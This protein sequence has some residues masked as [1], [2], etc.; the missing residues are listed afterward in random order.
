MAALLP[1]SIQIALSR[2]RTDSGQA[3]CRKGWA[4]IRGVAG[5][6]SSWAIPEWRV[7]TARPPMGKVQTTELALELLPHVSVLI[8]E[9]DQAIVFLSNL[10]PTYPS[11]PTK[12]QNRRKIEEETL[13][14]IA[15]VDLETQL[16]KRSMKRLSNLL[17]C[18]PPNI[19]LRVWNLVWGR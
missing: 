17:Y 12:L 14:T 16:G 7:W 6:R 1:T 4:R 3:L 10:L 2:G 9:P 19:G 8:F 5:S 13:W 15:M 11:V 18:L